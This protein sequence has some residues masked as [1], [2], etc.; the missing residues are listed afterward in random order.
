MIKDPELFERL[1]DE[2][3][4]Q[5]FSGWDFSYIATRFPG[6]VLSWD[7]Q[8]MVREMIEPGI[9]MMDMGTGDG[10]VLASL[11]PLPEE[12]FALEKYPPNV[13]K[14]RA[15]LKPLGVTVHEYQTSADLPY[16]DRS[17]DLVINRHTNFSFSEIHRILQT[18]GRFIT[19]QVGAKNCL[20][21]N[22]LLEPD[23]EVAYKHWTLDFVVRGLKHAGFGILDSSEEKIPIQVTD[24]GA[25]IFYLLHIPWQ[26]EGF[27]VEKYYDRLGDLHNWI[28]E[29]GPLTVET[30]RFFVSAVK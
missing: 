26:I 11:S 7:Y 14:A 22:N 24:I 12:T 13:F 3:K 30:H 20:Q 28:Q 5:E 27:T 23:K 9:S 6:P 19:Q 25:I 18:R 16:P 8:E 10:E 29:E 1:I 17:F 2:A 21:L 15:R 4:K